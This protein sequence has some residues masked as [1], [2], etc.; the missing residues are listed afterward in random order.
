MNELPS[1]LRDLEVSLQKLVPQSRLA[2][3]RLI[4]TSGFEAGLAS[5]PGQGVRQTSMKWIAAAML[6][7]VA[8]TL[9]WTILPL[10]VVWDSPIKTIRQETSTKR[11]ASPNQYELSSVAPTRLT[12]ELVQGRNIGSERYSLLWMGRRMRESDDSMS[13]RY[14]FEQFPAGQSIKSTSNSLEAPTIH[15]LQ[16]A[17]FHGRN[18]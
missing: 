18:I 8:A 10:G 7:V 13:D 16:Q 12:A 3:D 4:Y 14:Q 6:V 11:A 5:R 9:T 2:T 1:D 17:I 15:N